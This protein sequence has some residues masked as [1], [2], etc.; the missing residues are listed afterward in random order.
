MEATTTTT[1]T[2]RRRGR[3]A[4]ADDQVRNSLLPIRLRV[5]EMVRVA[6]SAA[7]ARQNVS[8]W[9]RGRLLNREPEPPTAPVSPTMPDSLL[10]VARE[11]VKLATELRQL[12]VEQDLMTL[13]EQGIENYAI[14]LLSDRTMSRHGGNGVGPSWRLSN[15]WLIQSHYTRK[16]GIYWVV[17]LSD[18][19]D[20]SRPD[21]AH[22]LGG[23]GSSMQ[24]ALY[25]T[26]LSAARALVAHQV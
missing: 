6:N 9:V 3:P 13:V 20:F 14:A 25:Q 10:Y 7:K 22:P 11:M 2:P 26:V 19:N 17:Y 8:E 24:L 5:D 23:G 1:I 21:Y 4:L 18:P 12:E 16:L 15:D